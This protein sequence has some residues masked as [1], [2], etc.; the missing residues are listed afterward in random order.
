MIRTPAR[1]EA[2]SFCSVLQLFDVSHLVPVFV[3][4][5]G[6]MSRCAH[7]V[8]SGRK[9]RNG[10]NER[11]YKVLYINVHIRK[12]TILTKCRLRSKSGPH[13]TSAWLPLE[14]CAAAAPTRLSL[15]D[16]YVYTT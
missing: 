2:V 10:L 15:E 6:G 12:F 3:F 8:L 14:V 1:L 11:L 4:V 13:L 16:L 7:G 9:L 5:C